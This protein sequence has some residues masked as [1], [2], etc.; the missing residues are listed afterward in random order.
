VGGMSY[1]WLQ[2]HRDQVTPAALATVIGLSILLWV[3]IYVA[4]RR[5]R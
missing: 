5:R 2:H 1:W 3:A 4:S